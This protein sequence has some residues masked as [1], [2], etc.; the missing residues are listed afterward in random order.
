M[1]ITSKGQV[2]IPI[3]VRE[4]LGLKPGGEIEF[5]IDS[6]GARIVPLNSTAA[7]AR[8]RAKR[9]AKRMQKLTPR[10][11]LSTDELMKLMRGDDW[12]DLR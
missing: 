12:P 9:I 7:A 6:D 3:A 4:R 1:R 10:G 11:G 5:A 8:A 2:T